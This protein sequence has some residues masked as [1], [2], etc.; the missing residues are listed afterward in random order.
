MKLLN[1]TGGQAFAS[2]VHRT[3]NDVVVM[4]T[5]IWLIVEVCVVANTT[6]MMWTGIVDQWRQ[7]Q[8][9]LRQAII[10]VYAKWCPT[11]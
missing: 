4:S 11:K 6:A 10:E 9:H 8:H 5:L 3:L 1:E 7:H 2:E